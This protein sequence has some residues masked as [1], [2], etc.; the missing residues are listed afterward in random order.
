MPEDGWDV[1][2]DAPKTAAKRSGL[3]VLLQC[4]GVCIG[5]ACLVTVVFTP[6][7]FFMGGHFHLYPQWQGWGRLHS[8]TA[9]D[10]ALFVSFV[11]SRSGRHS[12]PRISGIGVLCT[13][14]GE[15]FD[16]TLAGEL[17]R[18]FGL[19]LQGRTVRLYLRSSSF[20]DRQLARDLR[21]RINL[22]G[23]WNNPDLVMDDQGTLSH[24]FEPDGSLYKG[25]MKGRPERRETVQATLHQG[26]RTEFDAACAGKT[27]R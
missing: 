10:F 23:R 8:S 11:P 26:G 22:S 27:K 13:P 3:K 7:G 12:G 20:I 5:L 1:P 16:L 18:H 2:P 24:A 25:S 4:L 17:E 9:G 6:W 15:R 21:P 19:D 14:R